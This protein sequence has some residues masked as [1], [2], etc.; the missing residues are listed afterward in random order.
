MEVPESSIGLSTA[1]ATIISAKYYSVTDMNHTSGDYCQILGKIHPVD[2]LAPDIRFEMDLPTTWNGKSV[3]FGG[4]GLDGRIPATKEFGL[5][6]FTFGEVAGV[7]TPLARGYMTF[8]SDSGHQ[9]KSFDAMFAQNDEALGNYAGEH[10][11]KTHDVA[12][13]LAK[14]RY[15]YGFNHSYFVG[16]SGGGRQALLAAQRYANDYDGIIATFPISQFVGL[17]LGGGRISQASLA[18]GGFINPAK[19]AIIT[20][21]V[22]SQ[23]DALDGLAD[24]LISNPA[25]CS[26]DPAALRCPGGSDMGDTCLSDAQI[27]TVITAATPLTTNYQSANGTM[28]VPG[29]NIL[30]GA[31][32][33]HPVTVFGKSQQDAVRDPSGS[34]WDAGSFFWSLPTGLLRFAIARDAAIDITAVNFY[35]LGLLT[36]RTETVSKMMDATSVDLSA[37]KNR[38]GKL[39]LQHG[40]ADQYVPAQMSVNYYERL[41]KKYG[42]AALSAFLKFYLVPGV[43]HVT[44]GQ[45]DGAYDSL[46]VLD[47]WVT[48]GREPHNLVI[49]DLNLAMKGRTRPLC[50][51][52]LWPKYMSGDV[53][54]ATSFICSN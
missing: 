5:T 18:P 4:G 22:M 42:K 10:I 47:Q 14:K 23:C 1:G 13:F 54:S 11:K 33:W 28:S 32:L 17:A 51:Y 24:G 41:L 50:E 3:H 35:D 45:F 25:L 49:T 31:D 21:A 52:P 2:V 9:A 43:A 15:G 38:G 53:N 20:S 46:S 16:G 7:K 27:H 34:R 44:G 19:G 37:F 36:A 39:I 48:Q 8:G 6:G 12:L 29:Y 40:L 30:S 26:F